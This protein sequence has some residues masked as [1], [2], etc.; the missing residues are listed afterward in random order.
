[1]SHDPTSWINSQM[2][3]VR[4]KIVSFVIPYD[5]CCMELDG[6]CSYSYDIFNSL[7]EKNFIIRAH[8]FENK[9]NNHFIWVYKQSII[10]LTK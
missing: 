6:T 3:Q 10:T 9:N 4:W 7:L 2:Q 8:C 5:L 1:M